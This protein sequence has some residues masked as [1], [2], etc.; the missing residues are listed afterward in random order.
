MDNIKEQWKSLQTEAVEINLE[1]VDLPITGVPTSAHVDMFSYSFLS[2][3]RNFWNANMKA[4]FLTDTG[5]CFMIYI[6][7]ISIPDQE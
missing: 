1:V 7:I 3:H 4:V 6:K 2:D 5:L